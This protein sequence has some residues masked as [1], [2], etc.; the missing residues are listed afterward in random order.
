MC[1]YQEDGADS[2]AGA[3][4][5]K[6]ITHSELLTDEGEGRKNCNSSTALA[7]Y[8]RQEPCVLSLCVSALDSPLELNLGL[9]L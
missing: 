1:S 8:C 9:S 6:A 2:R 7:S 5:P 3:I 4:T